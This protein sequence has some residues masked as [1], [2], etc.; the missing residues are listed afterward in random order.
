MPALVPK[1]SHTSTTLDIE[2]LYV[3]PKRERNFA[4]L[5]GPAVTAT[6]RLG[7]FCTTNGR[8]GRLEEL[9]GAG[10]DGWDGGEG[11]FPYLLWTEEYG[12]E[13]ERGS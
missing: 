11:P 5:S 2:S 4:N 9:S 10:G 1:Q 8:A 3:I 6:N 12:R 7:R 13:W